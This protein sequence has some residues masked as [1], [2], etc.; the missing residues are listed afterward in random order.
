MSE[1]YQL[2]PEQDI[3]I[4]RQLV[5]VILTRIK[6]GTLGADTKLPTVR[7]LAEQLNVA[8]GTVKRAY[9]ELERLGAVRKAQ[10]RGTFVCYQPASSDSRKERA[11]A[12]IDRM[13]DTMEELDF[14]LTEV[15]IF[16]N[17]KLRQRS[18]AR[19]DLKIAVVECNPETLSQLLDQLYEA[20]GPADLQAHLLK[21]VQEYPYRIGEDVDL[22]VTSAEHADVLKDIISQQEKIARVALSLTPHSAAQLLKLTAG[23]RLGIL[24]RSSRFGELIRPVCTAYTESVEVLSPRLLDK[25]EG[26]DAYL[27]GLDA[28]AVPDGFERYCTRDVLQRLQDFGAGHPL[29][30]CRY[31]VDEGS[32][33]YLLERI[34]GLRDRARV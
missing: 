10:G 25:A 16:L 22:I 6:N 20:A 12:A 1:L 11:M 28:L 9:D 4:Y 3:S 26:L 31:Q 15:N 30:R 29:I 2:H 5:D 24:C 17:L 18:A 23:Q 21:D 27:A 34:E 32:L 13:L 33:M 8:R 14:S 7:D 19:D